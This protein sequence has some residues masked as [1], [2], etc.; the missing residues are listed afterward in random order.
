M[1]T[2]LYKSAPAAS[3]IP[4]LHSQ[5]SPHTSLQLHIKDSKFQVF[6]LEGTK[7]KFKKIETEKKKQTKE[8]NCLGHSFKLKQDEPNWQSVNTQHSTR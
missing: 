2:H 8:P 6:K 3:K 7:L 1:Q 5:L 4:K